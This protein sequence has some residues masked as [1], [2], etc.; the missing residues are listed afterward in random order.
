M[1]TRRSIREL[2]LVGVVAFALAGLS[3]VDMYLP[4]PY[5][6][7]VL[8][9]DTPGQ[10]RVRDVVPGS[11]AER[12]GIAP[13]DEI[14]GIAR[15]L[16]RSTAQAAA[17]L[18]DHSIGESVPY[19]VRRAGTDAAADLREVWVELGRR[20]IGDTSYLYAC[21]LGFSFFFIGLF[22]LRQQPSLRAS[23]VFFL[24]CSLFLVFLVCRLRPA[25]YSRIDTF[26]LATGT[27]A[28]VLLPA[29]FVHFFLIFPRPIWDG[30]WPALARLQAQERLRRGLLT[31]LYLV[32]VV[33][34]L[35]VV[36][37][38]HQLRRPPVLISGAPA[39]SWW[40]LAV[41]FLLGLLALAANAGRLP[42]SGER[43]GA[44]LVLF[45]ATFGLLPF[46]VLAVGFPSFLRTERFLF[47]GVVPLAL[48]P[49]TFSYAIIRYQLLNVRVILRRSLLY[50]ATTAVVT[51]L[52]AVGIAF[53]TSI[54]RGTELA[55]SPYFPLV[56]ALA[57]VLLF[58][59]LRRRIQ[60]PVDRFFFAERA[61]LQRAM[62]EMGEAFTGEI[63]PAIVVRDLVEK[64]PQ[65]LGIRFAA[66]YLFRS[67]ELER[68][69]GPD[70]L[71]ENLALPRAFYRHLRRR[72]TLARLDGL[73]FLRL[74]SPDVDQLARSLT[75]LGV[76]VVGALAS[77][78]R[79]IGL[80]L[81]SGKAG[82]TALEQEELDLLRG[83]F[84]QAA[85]ALETSILLE[86]RAR[87]AELERELEIASAIQR[88]LLPA[89][90]GLGPTWRV[91]AASRAARHVGGDFYA[92]LPG[93]TPGTEAVIYGDVSGKSVP[94]AL[95]M[96][97]AKE[98]FHSLALSAADPEELFR[99]ANQR[100]Y[101][102]GKRS[103][104]ALGYFTPTADGAG[105]TYLIAG[106][107]QPMKRLVSGEIQLLPLPEHRLPLGAL[108]GGD[109]GTLEARLEPGELLLAF[110]DG[111]LEAHSPAG[112]LFGEERVAALLA[113]APADPDAVVDR[114]LAALGDF[115]RGQ[116]PYDDLTVI[117]V[118][119]MLER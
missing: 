99:L 3:I 64:L 47:W 40:V 110:S 34:L 54:S 46:L 59:P 51:A 87:Q 74:R 63:D 65:I 89:S 115:T 75:A 42:S 21:L 58:E 53:F 101:D 112:E 5:D 19:L 117:A 39:A 73:E 94:G 107:P 35:A 48:I 105:L 78:R 56:F 98:V 10:L 18:N 52:Y 77:S 24:L 6:G 116:E 76:E 70:T 4:R 109:Y 72:A 15:T 71:P 103:F 38:R 23:R 29:C 36:W 68:V 84:H 11:G 90:L 12:A 88:S 26:V 67:R 32:P 100:L 31:G 17:L 108:R 113:A 50:T 2:A 93:L 80:V 55:T 82:Q 111:V 60:V 28:L 9:A 83:L 1:Q 7:V 114:V 85:I 104:V 118:G 45:G 95:M 16:L 33:V 91:A 96:M 49:L 25:S 119:R 106:Q 37:A 22:V 86:E 102:L 13:G 97:A 61:R 27:G 20:Q 57:I 43:R 62:V 8:D 92:A 30:R 44:A 66:L 79:R 81:L 41:F 14:V 69:A